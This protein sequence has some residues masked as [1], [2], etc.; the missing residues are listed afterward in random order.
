[1]ESQKISIMLD[2]INLAWKKA[3]SNS[4]NDKNYSMYWE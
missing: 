2:F 4:L 1:M 3:K